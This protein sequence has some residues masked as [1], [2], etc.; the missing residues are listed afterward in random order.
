M[1]VPLLAKAQARMLA[2]GVAVA[3]PPT[4]DLPTALRPGRRFTDE[5]I[6]AALPA[7]GPFGVRDLRL[8]RRV[9]ATDR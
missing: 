1:R 9:S 4:P 3:A 2:E 6:R 5:R 8:P 7:P